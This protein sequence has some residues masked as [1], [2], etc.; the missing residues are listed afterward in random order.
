MSEKVRIDRWLWAVRLFK[1]RSA[2]NAACGGGKVRV[3]GEVA[4]PARK[5]TVADVVTVRRRGFDATYEVVRLLEKR[6][7]AAI[8]VECY[9]DKTPDE[10]RAKAESRRPLN[11]GYDLVMGNRDRGSGRPTKRE[12]RQIDRLR[13]R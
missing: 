7:G 12:R 8:A 10:E 4:K 13:G 3:N 6:V 1:T 2:A 11:P 9:V 5:V